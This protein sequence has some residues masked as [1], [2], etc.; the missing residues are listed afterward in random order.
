[1]TIIIRAQDSNITVFLMQVKSWIH[2]KEERQFNNNY[3]LISLPIIA[4]YNFCCGH[5]IALCA[6]V[7]T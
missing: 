2:C 4:G 5:C 7:T 1:M 3:L 6:I